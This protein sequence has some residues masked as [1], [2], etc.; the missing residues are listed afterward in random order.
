[1]Q[2][3]LKI[4]FSAPKTETMSVNLNFFIFLVLFAKNAKRTGK[5]SFGFVFTCLRTRR[6]N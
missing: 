4:L 2:S 6:K 5:F 1:M 3:W